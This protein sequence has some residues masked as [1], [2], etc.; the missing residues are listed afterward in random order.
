MK[1]L[2]IQNQ[3][4]PVLQPIGKSHIGRMTEEAQL[5]YFFFFFF[6]FIV[7]TEDPQNIVVQLNAGAKSLV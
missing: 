2:P 1:C 5:L 4:S 3:S 6:N 7:Y